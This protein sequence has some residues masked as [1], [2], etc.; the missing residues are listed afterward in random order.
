MQTKILHVLQNGENIQWS[1][2]KLLIDLKAEKTE[3]CH[4]AVI[5]VGTRT[6]KA[7]HAHVHVIMKHNAS[8]P[9]FF[10]FLF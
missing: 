6:V 5:E 10:L 3:N 7:E 8:I 9:L 1:L 4:I 2:T